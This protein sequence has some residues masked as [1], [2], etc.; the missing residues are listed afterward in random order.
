MR[1]PIRASHTKNRRGVANTEGIVLH[2]AELRVRPLGDVDRPARR[3]LENQALEAQK[4]R[5]VGF[6]RTSTGGLGL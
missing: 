2:L 1:Q 3:R 4:Y 5:N 6:L